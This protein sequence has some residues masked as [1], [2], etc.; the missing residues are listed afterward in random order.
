MVQASAARPS[1][2]LTKRPRRR[3]AVLAAGALLLVPG[4][5]AATRAEALVPGGLANAAKAGPGRT[6]RVI[7]QGNGVRTHAVASA[8]ES[9]IAANPGRALGLRRRFAVIS[10]V[11]AE[12]TGRQI[13]ALAHRHSILAITPDTQLRGSVEGPALVSAPTIAG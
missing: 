5:A 9:E 4:P 8:V 11:A 2:R 7:V 13:L 12:L 1:A 3:L 6:F 10:G